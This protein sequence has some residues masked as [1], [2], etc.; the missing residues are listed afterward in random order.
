MTQHQ[1]QIQTLPETI[2]TPSP[3]YD[4]K[5]IETYIEE[6]Q[7]NVAEAQKLRGRAVW[8]WISRIPKSIWS[9]A[10]DIRQVFGLVPRHTN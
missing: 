3:S 2:F 7:K 5:S 4:R 6:A 1:N 8:Y 10:S 9:V